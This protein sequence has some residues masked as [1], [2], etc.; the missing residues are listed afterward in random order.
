MRQVTVLH[1]IFREYAVEVR[2]HDCAD[3]S[4]C[5]SMN[6]TG[7]MVNTLGEGLGIYPN[8]SSASVTVSMPE[9]YE[10]IDV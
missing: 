1:L 6:I 7:I 4:A 5:F 9:P 3:T 10:E 8:P 2:Q